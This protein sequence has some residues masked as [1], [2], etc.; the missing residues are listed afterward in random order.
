MSKGASEAGGGGRDKLG[1]GQFSK[2]IQSKLDSVIEELL[3]CASE[4]EVDGVTA[5]L[6]GLPEII[7][8]V[9][10]D[11]FRCVCIA[12]LIEHPCNVKCGSLH[13]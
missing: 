4:G 12:T 6:E 13:P 5:L 10:K 3:E 9:D 11:G 7:D 2:D 1:V 8:S